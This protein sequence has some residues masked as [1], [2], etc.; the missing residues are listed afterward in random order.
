[1]TNPQDTNGDTTST[2]AK[3]P[4]LVRQSFKQTLLRLATVLEELEPHAPE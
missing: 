1:M 3:A 4:N 2:G